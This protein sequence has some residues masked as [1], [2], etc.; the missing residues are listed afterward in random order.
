LLL[1][2]LFQD[3]D[4]AE[5]EKKRRMQQRYQDWFSFLRKQYRNQRSGTISVCWHVSGS[6]EGTGTCVSLR[7]SCLLS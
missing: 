5:I 6:E 7:R 1:A 3:E 2:I 4:E